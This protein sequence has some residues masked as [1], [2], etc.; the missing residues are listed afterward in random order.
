MTSSRATLALI[1]LT[2]TTPVAHAASITLDGL[3][4]PIVYNAQVQD[5]PAPIASGVGNAVASGLKWTG[6]A[7]LGAGVEDDFLAW[8]FDLIHPISL[9]AT[10]EYEVV[11]A[12]YSNSYLLAGAD[13]RVSNLFNANYDDLDATD[14]VEAAAF[15]LAIWE[16]AND[17]DFDLT[18]GVFQASGYGADAADITSTAQTFLSGGADFDGLSEWQAIFLE[19]REASGT[20]NLVTAVRATEVAPIPVPAAGFLLLGGL[21]GLIALRRS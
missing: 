21:F 14:A 6:G 9:G 8:C 5:A 1:A 7:D 20:Q 17:D 19:T 18:S 11:D 3:T 13:A 10:Y 16:V 12:P 2:T 15:Q 4:T